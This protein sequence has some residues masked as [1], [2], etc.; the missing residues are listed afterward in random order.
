[1]SMYFG[2]YETLCVLGLIYNA[3]ATFKLGTN[4]RN[5]SFLSCEIIV[6][7]KFNVSRLIQ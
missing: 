7:A 6:S 5:V 2:D 4:K 3:T 1:M